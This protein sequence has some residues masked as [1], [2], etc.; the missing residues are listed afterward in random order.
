MT[1]LGIGYLS[2]L[3]DR[4]IESRFW[5]MVASANFES[6]WCREKLP[7]SARCFGSIETK[8][9]RGQIKTALASVGESL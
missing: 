1:S 3:F 8:E 7:F 5:E 4:P 9:L 6:L 2:G